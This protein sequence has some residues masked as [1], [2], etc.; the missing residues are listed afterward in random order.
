MV[1]DCVD[2][3]GITIPAN[4]EARAFAASF[5]E[6]LG[7]GARTGQ[8]KLQ[9]TPVRVMPGGLERIATDGFGL[10]SGSFKPESEGQ[11]GHDDRI[12]PISGEKIVYALV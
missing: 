5:Y 4:A 6:Y 2:F 3:I 1:A 11:K 7:S 9:P 12:R 10:L 8:A